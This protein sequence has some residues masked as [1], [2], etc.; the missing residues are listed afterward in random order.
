MLVMTPNEY[1][2]ARTSPKFKAVD[3]ARIIP[4][5]DGQPGFYFARLEYADNV[6]ALFTAEREERRKPVEEA[7]E[8][9]GQVVT[10]THSR[11]DAGS[12]KE[13]FDGDTFT[14]VRGLEANPL[15]FDVAFSAPQKIP[16]LQL[17][18]G[19]M[20]DFT[21]TLYAYPPGSDQPVKYEQQFVGL[22]ADPQVDF[23]LTR[24]PGDIIRLRMEI[25]N[26]LSGDTAQIHVREIVFR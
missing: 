17:T 22:P 24:G 9:N 15:V 5:P 25:K 1:E 16:S 20:A 12:L 18:F 6:D 14:L 8:L 7:F 21:L 3:V 26:N 23:P 13:L 10:V 4:Y 19:S 2:T 11:L